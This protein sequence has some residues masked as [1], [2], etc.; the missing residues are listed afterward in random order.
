MALYDF[1]LPFAIRLLIFE[2][3]DS[4]YFNIHLFN[5]QQELQQQQHRQQQP[6]QRH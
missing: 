5:T 1:R 4:K 3:V 2:N 6:H